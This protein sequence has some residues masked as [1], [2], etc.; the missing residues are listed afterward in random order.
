[1]IPAPAAHPIPAQSAAPPGA[2]EPRHHA[3]LPSPGAPVPDRPT[4]PATGPLRHGH[5]WALADGTGLHAP[6]RRLSRDPDTGQVCCHL[7]GRW[8]R[9]LGSH[10]R[11]HGYTA[12][13]Y[14]EAMGLCRTRALSEPRLS[15]AISTR[16]AAAYAR[17]PD[18]RARFAPGQ[19]AARSGALTER[20]RAAAAAGDRPEHAEA[21]HRQLAAGRATA[22]QRRA[23]ALD[24]R[25]AALGDLDLG[26]YLRESYASGASLETLAAATG[27]GRARLRIAMDEAGVA[28]RPSGVNTLDGKRSRA[29][30]AEAAATARVGTEDLRSWLAHRYAAGWSLTRLAAA[31]GHSTPWVRWRLPGATDSAGT[32]P[33]MTDQQRSGTG[34]PA[35]A[36]P[37]TKETPCGR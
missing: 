23:D 3:G 13:S 4:V 8:F 35:G 6:P 19:E 17:D 2:R 30:A 15:A 16:Q 36:A 1:M 28:V 5:L 11:V 14:R 7:C 20:A 12:A 31:V 27:L 10:V 32:H 34:R 25:L 29:R 24:E 9:S 21:R 37:T 18:V 26:G 22:A 33:V